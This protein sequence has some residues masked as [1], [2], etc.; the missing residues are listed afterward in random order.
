MPEK[1]YKPGQLELALFN[2]S[3]EFAEILQ[4]RYPVTYRVKMMMSP[5]GEAVVIGIEVWGG[6]GEHGVNRPGEIYHF[7]RSGVLSV[8]DPRIPINKE[9]IDFLEKKVEGIKINPV[10]G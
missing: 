4:E 6:K 7:H 3:V 9:Y 10:S 2:A 1:S 8:N 5:Q